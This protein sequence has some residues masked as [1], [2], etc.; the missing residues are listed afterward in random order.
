[1]VDDDGEK[2][3]AALHNDHHHK[4]AHGGRSTGRFEESRE[5]QREGHQQVTPYE[6]EEEDLESGR[7]TSEGW[8][9]LGRVGVSWAGWG[10]RVDEYN[11]GAVPKICLTTP[12]PTPIT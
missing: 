6:E 11:I 8:V 1:M 2:D 5:Q 10:G 12:P 3:A 9:E 7:V 4:K